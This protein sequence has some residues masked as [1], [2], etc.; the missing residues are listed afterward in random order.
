ME[1]TYFRQNSTICGRTHNVTRK[2]CT[3]W[4]C[5]SSRELVPLSIVKTGRLRDS[6]AIDAHREASKTTK[7]I[8]E[9]ITGNSIERMN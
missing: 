9:M 5:F 4:I 3:C 6:G 7:C 2:G 1:R 8:Q